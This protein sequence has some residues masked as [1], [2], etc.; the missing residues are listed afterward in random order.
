MC[1]EVGEGRR[2][3]EDVEDYY[4]ISTLSTHNMTSHRR[5]FVH[6]RRTRPKLI[7]LVDRHKKFI[8][9]VSY[10]MYNLDNTG[11]STSYIK[12]RVMRVAVLL[13][14]SVIQIFVLSGV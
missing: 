13:V 11:D 5:R 1:C 14:F 6:K 9:S 12:Q 10:C 3:K 8:H 4:N 7:S 2:R